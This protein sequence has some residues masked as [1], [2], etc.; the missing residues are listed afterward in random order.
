MGCAWPA[1]PPES[2]VTKLDGRVSSRTVLG[3]LWR[4]LPAWVSSRTIREGV[5]RG[6]PGLGFVTDDSG[7]GWAAARGPRG[8]Q[9][10]AGVPADWSPAPARGP[11][12]LRI[13]PPMYN[14]SM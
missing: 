6:R 8:Y 2:S 7:G 10:A 4:A 11:P 5:G 9:G 1:F 14:G 13:T 3:G 12:A